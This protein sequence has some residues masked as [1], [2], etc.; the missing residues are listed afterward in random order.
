VYNVPPAVSGIVIKLS[1][2]HLRRTRSHVRLREMAMHGTMSAITAT[3]SGRHPVGSVRFSAAG[4]P[5]V[6]L[7]LTTRSKQATL[8]LT[9]RH[10]RVAVNYLGDA[11]TAPSAAHGRSG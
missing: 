8:I 3:V 11:N 2:P 5:T 6:T 7:P 10:T 4:G 1:C 9:R